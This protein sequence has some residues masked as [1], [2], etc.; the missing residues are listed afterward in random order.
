MDLSQLTNGDK[1]PRTILSFFS[2]RPRH[3]LLA[4][5]C[6]QGRQRRRLTMHTY[7]IKDLATEIIS[8]KYSGEFP[9][10]VNWFHPH[11]LRCAIQHFFL[12][13]SPFSITNCKHTCSQ[14]VQCIFLNFKKNE[15]LKKS[16][17]R[18][19][20]RPSFLSISSRAPDRKT[21]LSRLRRLFASP[22]RYT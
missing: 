8:I 12:F 13:K 5:G 16:E 22:Y 14:L 21:K 4:R 11:K 9:A 1:F 3:M 7:S 6:I 17:N 18:A 19:P 15:T 20:D 10:Y 2:L